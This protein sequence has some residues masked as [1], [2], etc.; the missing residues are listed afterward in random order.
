MEKP[1]DMRGFGFKLDGSRTQNRAIFI[2][3]IEEGLTKPYFCL[4][5]IIDLI[6]FR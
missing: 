6:L 4:F 5:I 2:S 3:T 1:V